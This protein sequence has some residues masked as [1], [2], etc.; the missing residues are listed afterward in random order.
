MEK[1]VK[2]PNMASFYYV[3]CLMIIKHVASQPNANPDLFTSG[4]KLKNLKMAGMR[5]YWNS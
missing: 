5:L 1:C 2:I 3:L 4:N